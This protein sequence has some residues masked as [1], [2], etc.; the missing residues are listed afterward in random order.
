MTTQQQ[1]IT[2]NRFRLAFFITFLAILLLG[3]FVVTSCSGSS[4]NLS[5]FH[6]SG[7]FK[8][9]EVVVFFSKSNGSETV[10]EGVVRPIPEENRSEISQNPLQY[11][12]TQLLIG[13]SEQEST[14]GFFSEIPKGTRLLSVANRDNTIRINLSQQFSSGGG[15]N[16]MQ[17]RLAELTQTVLAVEKVK[18]V[19]VDIEGQE[20]QVLG[21]EGVMVNEPIN[22][23]SDRPQ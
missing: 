4:S 12:I 8:S 7:Q 9:N 17:Q 23:Q 16:S 1:P 10:T 5:L 2:K 18:P 22:K 11:T 3:T 20:L 19:Y 14:Q 6:Q 13:P 21:G 15:S